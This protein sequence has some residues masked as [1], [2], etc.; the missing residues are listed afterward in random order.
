MKLGV[1]D[2]IRSAAL[3]LRQG[4]VP[5]ATCLILWAGV[6]FAS[7]AVLLNVGPSTEVLPRRV[8]YSRE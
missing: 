3:A 4:A 5:V 2:M 8:D 1:S 6:D 7:R